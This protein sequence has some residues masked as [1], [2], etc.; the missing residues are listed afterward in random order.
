MNSDFSDVLIVLLSFALL[1]M[2][3]GSLLACLQLLTFR[4]YQCTF[5]K[6]KTFLLNYVFFNVNI[7]CFIAC[8]FALFCEL[9]GYNYG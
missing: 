6:S 3:S 2:F 1:Q 7:L 5:L 4:W 8:Y 9:L